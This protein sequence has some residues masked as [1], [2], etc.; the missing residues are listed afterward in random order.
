M[1]LVPTTAITTRE[2]TA[3]GPVIEERTREALEASLAANTRRAYSTQWRLWSAWCS[4]RDSRPLPASPESV[5]EYLVH[6]AG[7]SRLATVQLGRSAI[8]WRHRSKGL[9]DPC[10]TEL[11]RSIVR[12]LERQIGQPRRQK[13]ALT[14]EALGAIR[15]TC[16]DT[17]TLA[18][19]HVMADGGLR[20]SEAA[21]LHWGDVAGWGDGSGRIV[22]RRSKTDVAGEG[23]T[24][25]VTS[26]TYR[27][28]E[29]LKD[30]QTPQ[31]GGEDSVFGLS[32]SQIA[33]RIKRAALAAGLGDDFSGHSGRIGMARRM[34]SNAAPDS[35]I[36][37]QGRWKSPGMV[38]AYT[39]GEAAGS[40][41]QYLR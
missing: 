10:A 14:A 5:A 37:R 11:V 18:L 29:R 32:D 19:V 12:G 1:E 2:E 38:A 20:R 30:A 35:A 25:A 41:L 36:M 3:L 27:L 34:A 39:R 16:R 7:S 9:P 26:R 28:L 6:R 22:V 21:A 31:D 17:L 40:A 24:V 33:R 4:E 8:S 23:A 13:G 15:A